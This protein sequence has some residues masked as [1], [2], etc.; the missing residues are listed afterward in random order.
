ME[1][2]GQHFK[3]PECT[4]GENHVGQVLNLVC[5][6]AKCINKSV[7]CGICFDQEH[8]GHNIKPLKIIINNSK[9]YLQQVTPLTL[10]VEKL[11]VNIKQ[12]QNKLLSSYEQFEKYVNES[13]LNIKNSI[14][15]IFIK[16]VD[17]I[18]LK[19]GKS[20]ELLLSLE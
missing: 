20:D 3:Y 5:L 18:E 2:K 1:A 17:Q 11:K 16:V 15:A 6:E 12:T 8:R 4:K 10:D 7:I 9:K 19:A 14:N 13:L